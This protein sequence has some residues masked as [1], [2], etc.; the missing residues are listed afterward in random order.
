MVYN[1]GVMRNGLLAAFVERPHKM[2]FE[3]QTH[4]EEVVLLL[5]RHW[6]T[7]LP[8]I[9]L[10]LI[11]LFVPLLEAFAVVKAKRLVVR[12]DDRTKKIRGTIQDFFTL[13]GEVDHIS[14]S[15]RTSGRFVLC[16]MDDREDNLSK[17]W[18]RLNGVTF[19]TKPVFTTEGRGKFGEE[20]RTYNANFEAEK[21]KIE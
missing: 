17:A 19:P 20:K 16:W 11:M 13:M 4:D 8:W 14:S 12:R 9:T 6:F 18:R 10:T 3:T 5:R 2:R 1:V 21:G 15:P 7:N